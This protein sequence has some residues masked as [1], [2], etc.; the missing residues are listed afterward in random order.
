[1]TA[2]RALTPNS[3]EEKHLWLSRC[4]LFQGADEAALSFAAS[5]A[6][7][8][9]CLSGEP[10]VL[11]NE[12]ND[13]VYFVIEGSVEIVIYLADEKRVQRLALLKP[14]QQFAEFSVLTGATKKGSAYA[15]ER[16]LLLR[17]KGNDFLELLE[18]FPKVA[19]KLV[20][21]L[22]ALNERVEAAQDFVPFYQGADLR[23]PREISDLIPIASWKKLG[24]I[25]LS[26]R[27]G[28]LSVAMLDPNKE[29]FFQ[30]ARTQLAQSEVN[31]YLIDPEELDAAIE[32]VKSW[33]KSHANSELKSHS[34][35]L[36]A[37][38]PQLMKEVDLL[39]SLPAQVHEQILP[40]IKAVLAKPG[41]VISQA[42]APSEFLYLV[43][44]GSI[45]VNRSVTLSRGRAHV[46]SLVAGDLMGEVSCLTD[47]PSPFTY[48][49]LEETILISIPKALVRQLLT[50]PLVSVPMARALALRLQKLNTQ[51]G[52]SPVAATMK[53]D[54]KLVANLLPISVITENH[55]VPLTAV[56]GELTLGLV[57]R[58][59]R[60]LA[61]ILNRYISGYR[62]KYMQLNQQQFLEL[63]GQIRSVQSNVAPELTARKLKAVNTAKPSDAVKVLDDILLYG[64]KARA[65]DVHFEPIEDGLV[66][67]HRIDGVLQE[68]G[69]LIPLE[70][71]KAMISRIKVLAGMDIANNKITQDGQLKHQ[72]GE[73]PVLARASVLPV[74]NGEKIVLR[75][76]RPPEN[77][78]PLNMI[79]PDK[80]AIKILQRVARS[81]QGLFLVT[82]PTGSGKTTTL[83][84]ILAELNRVGV[85]VVTIEDPVEL[86]VPG[87]NQ[88]EIDR[89]RGL[90][91]SQ[92]LPAVLRQD[93]DVIMVGEIRDEESAKIVFEAAVTGHLVLTTLHTS[94]STEVGP[95]LSELGVTASTMATGLLGVVSQRLVRGL[96]KQCVQSRPVSVEDRDW[97]LGYLPDA[98]I[99]AEL[100]AAQGC[101]ACHGTGYFDRLPVL[102]IWQTTPAIK[103]ALIDK[104]SP[105]ELIEI[106]RQDGF[107]T[108]REAG[109]RLALSG[110]T[111]IAEVKRC[112]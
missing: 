77:I 12:S 95:R 43:Q 108:L 19:T 17:L 103:K 111:T 36:S 9:T 84:S 80:R 63:S 82:G 69:E 49:A 48:R 98:Q 54:V 52:L 75:L 28:L 37:H 93:P 87:C 55:C 5:R 110:L 30:F 3:V 25:P 68:H 65:S 91:F 31:T 81:K 14:G 2:A 21:D 57:Q 94:F 1:M 89:K 11:E 26:Y 50:T 85:N 70:T 102:E 41:Q 53:F 66:V 106:A 22:A 29:E 73:T 32:F 27:S 16:S 7:A 96:C 6:E 100:K 64:L 86:E 13:H 67:R 39:R 38:L 4:L 20:Y 83:Y 72:I 10:I 24:V 23:L 97:I 46:M 56:D 33:I 15:F 34:T 42:G 35:P 92:V 51:S 107:Q 112:L 18:K 79:V 105:N 47:R 44:R 8:V 88:C 61:S 71:A 109:I 90:D 74:K 40:H 62:L 104:V 45:E 78:V 76:V 99:P 59:H 60:R 101:A 58:N